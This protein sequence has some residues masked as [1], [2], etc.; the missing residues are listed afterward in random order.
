MMGE[1][2]EPG[3]VLCWR[4]KPRDPTKVSTGAGDSGGPLE[5]GLAPGWAGGG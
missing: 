3:Q 1:G 2:G 5:T 4:R